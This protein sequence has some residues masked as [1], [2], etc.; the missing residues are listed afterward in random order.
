MDL[1]KVK[2]KETVNGKISESCVKKMLLL[3]FKLMNYMNNAHD[4]ICNQVK[5]DTFVFWV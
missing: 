1:R 3:R 5:I 2:K 4:L